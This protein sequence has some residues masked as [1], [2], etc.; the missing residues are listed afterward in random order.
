M[1]ALILNS[2]QP[3]KMTCRAGVGRA[4]VMRAGAFFGDNRN[5]KAG[6]INAWT[7]VRAINPAHN[8]VP[9]SSTW[10]VTRKP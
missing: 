5:L 8:T 1:P 9:D 3:A 6:G 2:N 4:G 10:T 7:R